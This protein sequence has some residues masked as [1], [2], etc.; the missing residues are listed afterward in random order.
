MTFLMENSGTIVVGLAVLAVVVLI[1]AKMVRDK[2]AGKHIGCDC[3]C[4]TCPHSGACHT[5]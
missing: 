1:V 2:R 3:G 4:E 5:E